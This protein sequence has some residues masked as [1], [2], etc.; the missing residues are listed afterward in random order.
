MKNMC[1][2]M[3]CISFFTICGGPYGSE[4]VISTI[5]IHN[6]IWVQILISILYVI[7]IIIIYNIMFQS[8]PQSK[9][10]SS[11][12][13][14]LFG[15]SISLYVESLYIF[16]ECGMIS[17]LINLS[18]VY[19]KSFMNYIHISMFTPLQQMII[20]SII[21]TLFTIFTLYMINF[22]KYIKYMLI[23]IMIPLILTIFIFIYKIPT[24]SWFIISQFPKSDE[25]NW[26]LALQYIMWL[27]FGYEKLFIIIRNNPNN[28]EPEIINNS[29]IIY[30]LLANILI[31]SLTYIISLW[32]GCSVLN[33]FNKDSE[34][35][36]LGN[37]FIISTYLIGR[38]PLASLIVIAACFSAI[39]RIASD[40]EYIHL[41]LLI[42]WKNYYNK[43]IENLYYINKGYISAIII[44]LCFILSIFIPQE[45]LIG[46]VSTLYSC[47]MF[48]TIIAFLKCLW[49]F[50]SNYYN[51]EI[52]KLPLIYN[53]D[54]IN[55]ISDIQNEDLL[56]FSPK[57]FE[58]A[59]YF[60]NLPLKVKLIIYIFLCIPPVIFGIILFCSYISLYYIGVIFFIIII[61]AIIDQLYSKYQNLEFN[62][63]KIV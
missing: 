46:S 56:L 41:L 62:N 3:L 42:K 58:D 37:F 43:D 1:L 7:P 34:A 52:L 39:G 2:T 51:H 32:S 27:N 63:G 38:T 55:N 24:S 5:G 28:I 13:K 45:Y 9:D 16:M 30:I 12:C 14:K 26:I 36:K 8:F 40:L 35:F 22:E 33:Y 11:W 53:E 20:L 61:T 59:I 49:K 31:I 29:K 44:T 17:S 50:Q 25:I 60:F 4:L 47:I 48:I 10:L 6:F 54:E 57:N 18:L 19:Q 23:I 15:T 21:L